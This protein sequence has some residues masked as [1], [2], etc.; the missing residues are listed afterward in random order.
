VQIPVRHQA[1]GGA[2]PLQAGIRLIPLSLT[3]QFGAMLVAVLAQKR[4]MPP[5]YLA[6]FG[7]TGQVIGIIFMS[8]GSIEHPNWRALYGLE[9]LTGLCVGIG[10]GVVTLMA[11]Y[12]TE[13]RDHGTHAQS[14]NR[15]TLMTINSRRN[16][17]HRAIPVFRRCH[18]PCYHNGCKQHLAEEYITEGFGAAIR[19]SCFSGHGC[20]Q[21]FSGLVA[22][23][24]AR[25]LCQEF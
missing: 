8:R 4:R 24:C 10:I 9:A 25:H 13:K 19:R 20:Y 18:G 23:D 12:A 5:V 21:Y 11:P 2:S 17:L 14:P 15:A 22:G 1:A 7:A 6:F 3:I 16:S